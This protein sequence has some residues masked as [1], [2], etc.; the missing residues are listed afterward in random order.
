MFGL[1]TERQGYTR[2]GGATQW[3]LGY[4]IRGG[5]I[6]WEAVLQTERRNYTMRGRGYIQGRDCMGGVTCGGGTS[7]IHA[8]LFS[9]S[10]CVCVFQF[11]GGASCCSSACR[12]CL[13][14]HS[15]THWKTPSEPPPASCVEPNWQPIRHRN[16]C[17]EQP[18][19]SSVRS[20]YLRVH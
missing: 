11:R 8:A 18:R 1:H 7:L 20:I 3:G 6:Y 2:R 13:P 10:E 15:A 4:T 12:C 14:L 9:Q 16:S 5:A 17:R 19:P